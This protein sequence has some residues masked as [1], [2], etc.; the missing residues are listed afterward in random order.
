VDI[1][2]IEETSLAGVRTRVV[3]L[4]PGGDGTMS[5]PI[6]PTKTPVLKVGAVVVAIAVT[7]TL[8]ALVEP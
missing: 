2:A 3:P 7:D 1:S 5:Q 8:L 6:Q 4:D